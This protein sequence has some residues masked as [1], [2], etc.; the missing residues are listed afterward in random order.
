[1]YLEKMLCFQG[2]HVKTAQLAAIKIMN[3]NEDEEEEIKL[4]INML[5]KVDL[6]RSVG[7]VLYSI[8]PSTFSF[9]C[10]VICTKTFGAPSG[11]DVSKFGRRVRCVRVTV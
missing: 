3:I 2:R 6:T 7:T 9:Y 8:P 1:M 10:F 4:E 11:R 5:K